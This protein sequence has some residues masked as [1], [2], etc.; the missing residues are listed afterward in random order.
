MTSQETKL[1]RIL[2]GLCV[3]LAL[4]GCGDWHLRGTRTDLV[5]IRTSQP[6]NEAAAINAAVDLKFKEISNYPIK[7]RT[8]LAAQM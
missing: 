2:C 3:L 8:Y 4:T 7:V 1:G 5:S 6:Y